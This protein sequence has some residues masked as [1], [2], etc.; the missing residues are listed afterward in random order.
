MLQYPWLFA[1]FMPSVVAGH[2]GLRSTVV[3]APAGVQGGRSEKIRQY[4]K[5]PRGG[6]TTFAR[7]DAAAG[8]G[9]GRSWLR[10][11]NSLLRDWGV[12]GDAGAG[13]A[14]GRARVL[15]CENGACREEEDVVQEE[16]EGD[17]E[18]VRSLHLDEVRD[19][20]PTS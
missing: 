5:Q 7:L 9:E 12:D 6:L 11:R 20:L 10:E 18:A 8:A 2:L 17:G 16:S 3:L 1:S 13:A 14:S 15:I 4:G 19:A